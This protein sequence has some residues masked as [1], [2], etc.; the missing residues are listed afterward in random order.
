MGASFAIR[1]SRDTGRE[2]V[3]VARAWAIAVSVGGA[4]DIFVQL[5]SA[6]PP[7]PPAA[8]ARCWFTLEAALEAATKWIVETQPADESATDLSRLLAAPTQEL[9]AALPSTAPPTVQAA[10]T[11]ATEAMATLG[12]PRQLAQRIAALDRL[13]ELFEIVYVAADTG[14]PRPTAAEMYHRVGEVVDLDWVRQTLRMLS[15]ED[16][17][18]RRAIEG[19]SEGLVYARRRLAQNIVGGNVRDVNASLQ[20]YIAAEQEQLSRLS[21]LIN[22]IKSARRPTLAALVVVMRELGRLVGRGE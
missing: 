21:A 13:A 11:A 7:L 6:D 20:A 1:V 22:D 18:E 12:T 2:V 3:A 8:E 19:L 4:S 16:R 15:A 9:L 14:V 5:G 10:L 17:W